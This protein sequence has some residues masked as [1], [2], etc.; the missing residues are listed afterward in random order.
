MRKLKISN[1]PKPI[2]PGSKSRV[3]MPI[4]SFSIL[5]FMLLTVLMKNI[6]RLGYEFLNQ[7]L[8]KTVLKVKKL[9]LLDYPF[10][11]LIIYSIPDLTSYYG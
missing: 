6:Y 2:D 4:N 3:G 5:L 7:N 10:A 11:I 9:I 8:N 1:S